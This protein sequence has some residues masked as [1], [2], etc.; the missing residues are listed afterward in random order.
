M[1]AKSV[2]REGMERM[3]G[4]NRKKPRD[5]NV[6]F[7][8]GLNL[9]LLNLKS[10]RELKTKVQRRRSRSNDPRISPLVDLTN[11][12]IISISFNYNANPPSIQSTLGE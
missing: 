9:W 6:G 4:D 11:A 3:R 1:R 12:T 2:L 8:V 7:K 5:K 10:L